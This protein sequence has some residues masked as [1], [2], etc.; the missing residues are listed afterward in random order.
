MPTNMHGVVLMTFALAV[1]ALSPLELA[2]QR[3]ANTKDAS[4]P[5][6]GDELAESESRPRFHCGS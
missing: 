6:S 4:P 5:V 2:A 1:A 3:A